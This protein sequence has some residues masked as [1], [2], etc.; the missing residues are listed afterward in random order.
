MSIAYA[1]AQVNKFEKEIGNLN[2]KVNEQNKKEI[3]KSKQIE[4]VSKSINK[5]TSL[6]ILQSKNRQIQGYQKDIYNI[7]KKAAELQKQIVGKTIELGKKKVLLRKE[8]EL[9]Q[10]KQ[11]KIQLDFQKKIEKDIL[12]Q[13][14]QLQALIKQN[15][16]DN[17]HISTQE[18]KANP[19]PEYD[20]FIS[21]ASEDKDDLVRPLAEALQAN[22][23]KIWYDEF[24]LTVG[25]S[26]RKNIDKGLSKSK[27]G[28]VIISPSFIKKNWTEYELNG[29]VAREMQG[30][31]VILPIWHKITKDEILNYSPFLADKLALN[32]A[33]Y[34]IQD[35]VVSLKKLKI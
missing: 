18:T 8:E 25:D 27:Y 12:K 22:S 20:F 31:K 3:A 21:H 34:S 35:I 33:T 4:N 23:F 26:L 7:K 11:Q 1:Q 9:E 10:K 32:T 19:E 5:T 30:H 28:I 24:E 17:Q 2:N 29:M 15:Y 14:E 16:S 6:S 13:K